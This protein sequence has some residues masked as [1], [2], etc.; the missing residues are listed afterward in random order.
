MQLME[1]CFD[2]LKNSYGPI[3]ERILGKMAVAVSLSE[4]SKY[5][6]DYQPDKWIFV[7][8]FQV[9]KALHYLKESHGVMHRGKCQHL[10]K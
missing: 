4:E 1:T 9:V 8:V 7:N 3:P 2:K 10:A 5:L 6:F